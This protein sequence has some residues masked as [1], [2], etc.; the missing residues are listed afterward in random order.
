MEDKSSKRKRR[1]SS[2]RKLRYVCAL[3]EMNFAP[4]TQE[5]FI[6]QIWQSSPSLDLFLTGTPMTR[7]NAGTKAIGIP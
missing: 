2:R 7:K 6:F 5:G 1:D 3:R 4:T